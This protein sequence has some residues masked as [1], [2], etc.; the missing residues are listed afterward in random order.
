MF[1]KTTISCQSS[2]RKKLSLFY[3]LDVVFLLSSELICVAGTV[4]Q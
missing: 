2:H 3:C 1:C 4:Y